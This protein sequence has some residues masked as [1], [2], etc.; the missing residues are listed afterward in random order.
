MRRL[1]SKE[2]RLT[3]KTCKCWGFWGSDSYDLPV[4][5]L[6]LKGFT[7]LPSE[8]RS[9]CQR[10][11]GRRFYRRRTALYQISSGST[12]E[13]YI[14]MAIPEPLGVND[15]HVPSHMGR[16]LGP[17]HAMPSRS[18]LNALRVLKAPPLDCRI[19]HRLTARLPP[20]KSLITRPST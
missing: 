18:Y 19:Q 5:T 7:T 1:R 16:K 12:P 13:L 3:N 6:S 15:S 11:Q 14:A 8:E 10:S 9:E 4:I 20:S 2:C 17:M